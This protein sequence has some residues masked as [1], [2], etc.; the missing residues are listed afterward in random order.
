M[1]ISPFPPRLCRPVPMVFEST[2]MCISLC[3]EGFM[4]CN[5]TIIIRSM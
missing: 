2:Q 1:I 5:P 4:H 3:N